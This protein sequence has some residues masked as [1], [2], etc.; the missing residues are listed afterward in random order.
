MQRVVIILNSVLS[1][2]FLGST[3]LFK[4]SDNDLPL[5]TLNSKPRAL[6]A[7]NNFNLLSTNKKLLL[8]LVGKV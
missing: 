4:L 1:I 7:F 8:A 5:S 3:A 6:A 2:G